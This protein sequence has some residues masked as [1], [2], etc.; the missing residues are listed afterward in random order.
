MLLR[1]WCILEI[2]AAVTAGIPIIAVSLRGKAYDFAHAQRTLTYLDTE[3]EKYNPGASAILE[4][5][6]V[7]PLDAAYLLSNVIPNLISIEFDA[8][9]S[10]NA[11]RA[12]I[13]DM[14]QDIDRLRTQPAA[15]IVVSRARW[16]A[17]R[18]GTDFMARAAKLKNLSGGQPT[19]GGATEASDPTAA[20]TQQWHD[21][22]SALSKQPSTAQYPTPATQPA[23]RL[24]PEVPELPK[25]YIV[26]ESLLSGLK[27]Q[28]LIEQEPQPSAG[29][30]ARILAAQG[31][32]GVRLHAERCRP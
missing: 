7:S 1:P 18:G 2:H 25:G 14:L 4:N 23:M 29:R 5:N 13:D 22:V 3:L 28:L 26:R 31:M 11:I 20:A 16:V 12:S 10:N 17:Q 15:E 24:P 32:G 27:A 19:T 9:G 8:A 6:N 21:T 30:S